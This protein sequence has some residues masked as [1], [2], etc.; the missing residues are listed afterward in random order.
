MLSLFFIIFFLADLER[1]ELWSD[2]D[3]ITDYITL[4]I[5]IGSGADLDGKRTK[6]IG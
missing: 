4:L 2:T 1:S 5:W 6:I 3:S